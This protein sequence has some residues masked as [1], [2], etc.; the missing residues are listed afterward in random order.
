MK[1]K[2]KRKSGSSSILV[3]FIVLL[4]SIFGTLSLISS[5]AGLKLAKKNA[6]WFKNV[7]LLE[8][9]GAEILSEISECLK[10]AEA[11]SFDSSYAR[12]NP[13]LYYNNF[14]KTVEELAVLSNAKIYKDTNGKD[15]NNKNASNKDANNED[16]SNKD[17]NNKDASSKDASNKD[18]NN[19]GFYIEVTIKSED[20][21]LQIWL[22]VCIEVII[23]DGVE[24][25]RFKVTRWRLENGEFT[26]DDFPELW[27]GPGYDREE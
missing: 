12:V 14:K 3:V 17:A 21:S 23:P 24:S 4:L 1:N 2:I 19:D 20:I 6:E 18:A 15:T 10:R 7:Y 26:Y 9:E 22:D 27:K 13:N 25:K 16:A 11:L 8:K 5:N